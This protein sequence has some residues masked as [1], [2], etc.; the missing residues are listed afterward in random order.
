MHHQKAPCDFLPLCWAKQITSFIFRELGTIHKKC[1][2]H[3]KN[4]GTFQICFPSHP[5]PIPILTSEVIQE[6]TLPS[7]ILHR[8]YS[9]MPTALSWLTDCEPCESASKYILCLLCIICYLV[10]VHNT[11]T[12][13]NRFSWEKKI[14]SLV[15]LHIFYSVFICLTDSHTRTCYFFRFLPSSLQKV[16]HSEAKPYTLLSL[17]VWFTLTAL[18]S[19]FHLFSILL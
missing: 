19:P 14:C 11:N 18:P 4:L 16:T 3:L 15:L 7:I 1:H 8:Q 5:M 10:T 17:S 13:K 12:L 6:I 9:Q 2:V